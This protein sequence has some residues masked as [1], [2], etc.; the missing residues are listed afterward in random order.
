MISIDTKAWS[1]TPQRAVD[2]LIGMPLY[3]HQISL[4]E[5][6]DFIQVYN[7]KG[8]KYGRSISSREIEA[9]DPGQC[10]RFIKSFYMVS[11]SERRRENHVS[12]K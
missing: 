12:P 7:F 10:P 3:D 8:R 11:C 9:A 5:A 4:C 6:F 2:N 1:T